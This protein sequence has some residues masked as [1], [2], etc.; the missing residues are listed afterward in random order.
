MDRLPAA[1]LALVAVVGFTAAAWG[2]FKGLAWWEPVAVISGAIG[3]LTVIPYVIAIAG[4][5]AV[6]KSTASRVL[7]A[8]LPVH[9]KSLSSHRNVLPTAGARVSV[10]ESLLEPGASSGER[11]MSDRSEQ[12]GYVLEGQLT[13]W[14][15][16]DESSATLHA[17]DAFQVPSYARL[18]YANQ[19]DSPAR[20]LWIYT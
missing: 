5:V 18:R 7:Q 20:V 17:G 11:Q 15:G 9:P 6:G 8:L 13:L 16:E 14:L 12:G 19:G 2:V 10:L 1:D 3:L 4:S